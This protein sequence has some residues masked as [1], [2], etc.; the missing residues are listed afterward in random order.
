MTGSTQMLVKSISH[1]GKCSISK[2]CH[3]AGESWRCSQVGH[4]SALNSLLAGLSA[5]TGPPPHRTQS[6]GEGRIPSPCQS[7]DLLSLSCEVCCLW[8]VCLCLGYYIV[9][10]LKYI[11]SDIDINQKSFLISLFI[12]IRI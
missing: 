1:C 7:S 6:P 4:H 11:I 2:L 9:D 5:P 12:L 8:C 10:T 3:S